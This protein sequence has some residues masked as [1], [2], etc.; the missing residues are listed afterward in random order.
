MSALTKQ[1]G[2]E[3]RYKQYLLDPNSVLDQQPVSEGG[4]QDA[5]FQQSNEP[6]AASPGGALTGD[7]ASAAE[8]AFNLPTP[9]D[10]GL[11]AGEARKPQDDFFSMYRGSS[12]EDK[13]HMADQMED[14]FAPHGLSLDGAL[15][16]AWSQNPEV[17]AEL[18]KKF[19]FVP[20]ADQAGKPGFKTEAQALADYDEATGDLRASEE[21]KKLKKEK[22]QAMGAFLF[23]MGL[24]ILA[25][26]R[27][28]AG[29]AI[30]EG[31]L[32]TLDSRAARKEHTEDREIAAADR[33][34]AAEDRD[35]KHAR[36]DASDERYEAEALRRQEIHDA[37]KDVGALAVDPKK[38]YAQDNAWDFWNKTYGD[39]DS[40]R[41]VPDEG[42]R[43]EDFLNWYKGNSRLTKS[44]VERM[45]QVEL[46][47]IDEGLNQPDGWDDMT[48]EEQRTYVKEYM[49]L[50]PDGSRT[51]SQG[52]D[53]K[54]S[55]ATEAAAKPDSNDVRGPGT[56]E[57]LYSDLG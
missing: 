15:Q 39:K 29:G 20:P 46:K 37:K 18:G 23:E 3:D 22:R 21:K 54:P 25:S 55:T 24:R 28:D 49:G 12:D 9:G 8:P 40:S 48:R 42:Q 35:R 1:S 41:Y 56:K 32:G 27:K 45:V 50:N 17:S 14:R 57:I 36:E 10:E 19:G 44:E 7:A 52:D 53:A 4:Q 33:E 5:A 2:I 30:A 6:Q 11:G 47:A 16:Q 38:N 13:D 31:A 51:P 34:T 26:N 43:R